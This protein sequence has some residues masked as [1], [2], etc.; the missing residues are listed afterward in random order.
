MNVTNLWELITVCR[1]F[2]H[3]GALKQGFIQDIT[4]IK[5]ILQQNG[6]VKVRSIFLENHPIW[7]S[8]PSLKKGVINFDR[9]YWVKLRHIQGGFFYSSSIKY[10]LARSC[11]QLWLKIGDKG[12]KISRKKLARR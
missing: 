12:D 6:G 4:K 3:P 10:D 11:F 8:H 1:I 7:Y 5:Q 2:L 9:D